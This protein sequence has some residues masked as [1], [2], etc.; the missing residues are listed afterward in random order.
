MDMSLRALVAFAGLMAGTAQAYDAHDAHVHGLAALDLAIKGKQLSVHLDSPLANFIGF[1][2][3][4]GTDAERQ[5]VVDADARLRDG[6][7]LFVASAAAR[8]TLTAVSVHAPLAAWAHEAPRQGVAHVESTPRP[9][10]SLPAR[11]RR[12]CAR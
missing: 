3:P 8:C 2:H 5:L 4:P 6:A 10:M 7:R 1:E 9:T 11:A 12:A